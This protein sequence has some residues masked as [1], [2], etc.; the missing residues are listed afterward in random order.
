MSQFSLIGQSGLLFWGFLFGIFSLD[1]LTYP[2]LS[3]N[4]DADIGLGN[5]SQIVFISAPYSSTYQYCHY[6]YNSNLLSF[7]F[8]IEIAN[9]YLILRV[10]A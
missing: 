6:Y 8:I 10:T 1:H 7:V 4:A 3:L 5:F 2:P 9:K